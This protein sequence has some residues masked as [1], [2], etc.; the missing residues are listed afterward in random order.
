MTA[1]DVSIWR[2][3]AV[4]DRRYSA[5]LGAE[6]ERHQRI[7]GACSG[8]DNDKLAARPRAIRH[9]DSGVFIRYFFAPGFLSRFLVER[10]EITIAA[11]DEHQPAA[12]YHCPAVAVGRS[13]AV[14]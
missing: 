10:I 5:L 6:R 12:G 13:Q 14:G 2:S 11:P 1:G 9:W 7:I 8:C 4:I 3:S